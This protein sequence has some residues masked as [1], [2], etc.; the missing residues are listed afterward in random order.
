MSEH[1]ST[2]RLVDPADDH[3]AQISGITPP[4]RR[5]G[6]SRFL[7]DVVVELGFADTE[8]VNAL[9]RWLHRGQALGARTRQVGCVQAPHP[10]EDR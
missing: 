1:D 3:Q 9:R 10:D 6:S 8:D 2:L 7:T 5:G 4:R